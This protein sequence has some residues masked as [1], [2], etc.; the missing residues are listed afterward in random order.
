[1]GR[2]RLGLMAAALLV[3]APAAFAADSPPPAYPVIVYS[4]GPKWMRVR[5]ADFTNGFVYPCSSSMNKQLFDGALE[6]GQRVTM[7]TSATCVCVQHSYDDFPDLNWSM[8]QTACRPVVCW[9]FGKGRY[10]RPAPDPTIR[11]TIWSTP[12]NN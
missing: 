9:G 4:A 8:G 5:V 12:P 6:P 3:V 2:G 1:M 7:Q 10:C 11:V